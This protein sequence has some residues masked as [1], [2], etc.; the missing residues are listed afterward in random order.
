MTDDRLIT[1][2]ASRLVKNTDPE[3]AT[4]LT[5]DILDL[6][7]EHDPQLTLVALCAALDLFARHYTSARMTP[8]VINRVTDRLMAR[9]RE[10]EP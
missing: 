1:A 7:W 9:L 5:T 4:V 2:I 6:V 10:I 3:E 8:E